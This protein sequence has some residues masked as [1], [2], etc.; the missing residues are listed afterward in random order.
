MDGTRLYP[1]A[2][3]WIGISADGTKRIW[4][5]IWIEPQVLP[6]EGPTPHHQQ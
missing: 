4:L 6:Y 1:G 2:N 5:V 3:P